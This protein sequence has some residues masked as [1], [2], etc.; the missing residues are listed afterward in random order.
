MDETIRLDTY[1]LHEQ[2]SLPVDS[3]RMARQ[4][5]TKDSHQRLARNV[6]PAGTFDALIPAVLGGM[7]TGNVNG[8]R[9]QYTIHDT[10]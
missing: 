7:N 1:T 6:F 4:V 10:D 5:R 8:V 2:V 9:K 3:E